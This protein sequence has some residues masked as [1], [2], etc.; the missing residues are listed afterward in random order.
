MPIGIPLI[1]RR[2]IA[3]FATKQF[4]SVQLRRS[5]RSFKLTLIAPSCSALLGLSPLQHSLPSSLEKFTKA[6]TLLCCFCASHCTASS[7]ALL[8]LSQ[9]K[10]WG[11]LVYISTTFIGRPP[12]AAKFCF[13]HAA[14]SWGLSLIQNARLFSFTISP[15]VLD[16]SPSAHSAPVGISKWA[17]GELQP[18]GV[19]AFLT[20]SYFQTFQSKHLILASIFVSWL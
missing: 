8:T 14:I 12:S 3:P 15:F 4:R 2:R 10:V 5:W 18:L 6:H 19:L 13:N 9:G 17:A 7:T 11:M 20:V 16:P 1:W